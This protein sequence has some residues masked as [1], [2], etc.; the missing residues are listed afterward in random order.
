MTSINPVIKNGGNT[1]TIWTALEP[2]VATGGFVANPT[3]EAG[4][5]KISLD[6]GAFANLTNLPGAVPGGSKAVRI[7]IAPAELNADIIVIVLSD[8]NGAQ[9]NDKIIT[10]ETVAANF[11]TI[12]GK[13]PTSLVG[14]RMDVSVGA[15]AAN[16]LTATAINTGALTAAKFASGAFDAVWSVA[17]RTVTSLSGVVADIRS[18]VGL[19]SPNLDTQFTTVTSA[20]SGIN[21]KLGTPAGATVSADIAAIKAETAGI[22]SVGTGSGLTA[23]PWNSAWDSHVASNALAAVVTYGGPTYAQLLANTLSSASYATATNLA[24]VRVDTHTTIP[25]LFSGLSTLSAGDVKASMVDALNVDLYDEPAQ[26]TP[27][28]SASIVTKLGF[29]YK[30]WRNRSTQ[31]ATTYQLYADDGATV[32]HKATTADDGARF[33]RGVVGSGP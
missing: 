21:T 32:H 19:A 30:A 23:I 33:T 11:D 27:A 4:D 7:A 22:S 2:R 17:A 9:W 26:G 29:L 10:I 15:M 16:V 6:G 1:I 3:F 31:S 20:T 14:G 18:A 28:A 5:A 8:Q 12:I 13:L 25:E 24:A